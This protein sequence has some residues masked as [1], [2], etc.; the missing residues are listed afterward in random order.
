VRVA[1]DF[2]TGVSADTRPNV[3]PTSTA[4]MF[5]PGRIL[6]VGGNGYYDGHPTPSSAQATVIDINGADP[7]LTETAP[8]SVGRQWANATVLPDGKVVVT[9][10][11]RRANNGGS[12]AVYHAELWDPATGTWTDGASAAVV[13]VY[14]SAALLMPN[15][16]VLSTGGGAPGPVN[17]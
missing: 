4:V 7:V 16:T 3:G 12:D 10:G 17:N 14:H 11:T 6:Q 1:G 5:A 15:G 13:R 2:K 9:G 8:M